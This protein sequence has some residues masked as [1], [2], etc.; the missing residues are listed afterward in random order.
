VL[1]SLVL[2]GNYAI[3][4]PFWALCSDTLPTATLATGSAAINTFAQLGAGAMS[5]VIGVLRD[6]TGCFPLALMPLCATLL[7]FMVGGQVERK[8]VVKL[9]V[10]SQRI[11]H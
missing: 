10:I 7:V 5:S 9:G 8:R 3:K 6:Q 1:L 11:H 4:W 2:M